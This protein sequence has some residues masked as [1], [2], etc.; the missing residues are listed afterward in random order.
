MSSWDDSVLGEKM[1]LEYDS[2]VK[3]AVDNKIYDNFE[4][5]KIISSYEI[6]FNVNPIDEVQIARNKARDLKELLDNEGL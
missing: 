3:I 4:T 2:W 5:E 1:M 6:K